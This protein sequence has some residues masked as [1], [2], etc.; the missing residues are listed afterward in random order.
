LTVGCG[1]CH[2]HK[3]DPI[4]QTDYYRLAALFAPTERREVEIPTPEERRAADARNAEIDRELTPLRERAGAL[5]RK[6]AEAARAGRTP[7]RAGGVDRQRVQPAHRPRLDEPRLAPALRSRAGG[8]PQQLRDQRRAPLASGT[9]GLAGGDVY[10]RERGTAAR[11]VKECMDPE[12]DPPPGSPLLH[13][14]AD[15]P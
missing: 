15:L 14:S 3:Y 10:E 1:R 2:D 11:P 6:G 4:K 12:A 13:L 8:H 7:P 5:R 9:V